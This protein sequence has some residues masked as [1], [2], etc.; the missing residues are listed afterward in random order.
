MSQEKQL[1]LLEMVQK[2]KESLTSVFIEV[3]N[4]EGRVC[5]FFK[6]YVLVTGGG[7]L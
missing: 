5:F 2:E 6:R 3:D 1:V 7:E 4:M